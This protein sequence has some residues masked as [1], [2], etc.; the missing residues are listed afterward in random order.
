MFYDNVSLTYDKKSVDMH[1][2]VRSGLHLLEYCQSWIMVG[3]E[4]QHMTKV[5]SC[6]LEV[7][8]GLQYLTKL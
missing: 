3:T 4:L 8:I 1:S 7:T 5:Q 2:G 6:L